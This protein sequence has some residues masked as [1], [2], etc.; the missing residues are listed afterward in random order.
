MKLCKPKQ[1]LTTAL[2]VVG[3]VA[4]LGLLWFLSSKDRR[5]MLN[6]SSLR[7]Q[8]KDKIDLKG[9]TPVAIDPERYQGLWFEQA[10]MDSYFE[11]DLQDVTARYVLKA[12]K[13]HVEVLNSGVRTSSK[14]VVAAEGHARILSQPG[15]LM[16]AF[17]PQLFEG[18]YVVLSID[19]NYSMAVVGSPSRDYAWLLTRSKTPVT[20]AQYDTFV[21]VLR[22]N[23]YSAQ[24]IQRCVRV[25][26]TQ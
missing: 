9:L 26:H 12:D 7:L 14:E 25:V 5:K 19:A 16:V 11:K 15:V 20:S 4:F 17:G 8:A 23:G 13:K 1:F 3:F 6:D 2:V 10:R 18:A 22:K 24:Q 21:N